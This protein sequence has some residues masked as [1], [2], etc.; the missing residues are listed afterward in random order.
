MIMDSS[1]NGSWIIQFKKF[2][3]LRVKWYIF[4]YTDLY[5]TQFQTVRYAYISPILLITTPKKIRIKTSTTISDLLCCQ[6]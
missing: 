2:S 4:K 5:L 3:R 1:K 6:S